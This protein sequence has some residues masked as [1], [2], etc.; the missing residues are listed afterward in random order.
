[1]AT[2]R[3]PVAIGSSVPRWPTLDVPNFLRIAFSMACEVLRSGLSMMR[4]PCM[5]S[6]E[7]ARAKRADVKLL[8]TPA[9]ARLPSFERRGMGPSRNQPHSPPFQGGVAAQRPGWL[10]KVAQRSGASLFPLVFYLI[11]QLLDPQALFDRF[12][13][14]ECQ[15]RNSLHVVQALA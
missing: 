12:V 11:Q 4:I 8:T 7:G 13:I 10:V 2:G 1:M 5:S 3:T 14:V 15:L 9:A 6:A